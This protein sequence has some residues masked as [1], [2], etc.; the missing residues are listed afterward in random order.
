MN[1]HELKENMPIHFEA[2]GTKIRALKGLGGMYSAYAELPAGTDFTP[3]LQGL[4]NDKCH[5]PH[6]IALSTNE[7]PVLR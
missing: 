7:P 1:M 3:L 4:P 6:S 2:P 5:C